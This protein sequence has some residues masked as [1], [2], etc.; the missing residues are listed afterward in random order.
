MAPIYLP[1]PL[2]GKTLTSDSC[3]GGSVPAKFDSFLYKA[4]HLGSHLKLTIKL[5]INLRQ[6][7]PKPIPLALDAD[8]NPFWTLPWS[9]AGWAA[10]ISAAAAQ[11][12]MWNNKFWL[13]PPASFSGF[14]EVYELDPFL[15]AFP[16]KAFRPN[17]RCALDVDFAATDDAQRTID[18]ANL[19]PGMLVLQG[20]PLNPGTFRSHALLYDSL[21]TVPWAFPYGPGPGQP[22]VHYVIAHEIGH[23]MGLGHIGTILKT[24]LCQACRSGRK[25]FS[26]RRQ[27]SIRR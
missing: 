22:T 3:T 16:N 2:A 6:L 7:P 12:D 1:I 5:R 26:Q 11:A 10:F 14:D 23:A 24:P 13:L 19:N 17:I 21:D 9:N 20:R 15:S 27:P 4:T 8:G 18:V 25:Y